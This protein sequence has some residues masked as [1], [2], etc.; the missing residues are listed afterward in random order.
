MPITVNDHEITD[1]EIAAELPGHDTLHLATMAVILRH[2]LRDEAHRL[3]LPATDE[4]SAIA[5]LLAHEV[6]VPEADDASCRRHYAQ[7]P[8][9]FTVGELVEAEHILFQVTERVPLPALRGLAEQTLADL[10]AEPAQFG[11]Q[12]RKLSNCPSATLG[13]N[14]GQL[15]R[16]D[17]VPEFERVLFSADQGAIVPRVVE[18]RFGLHI[19]R[20]VHR[21]AG[22]LLPYE[23]V[24]TQ[25]A[26]ALQQASRDAAWRQYLRV[27]ASR[28]R[29]TGIDLDIADSP[30]LQ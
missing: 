6:T 12:A 2:L 28:A 7:N 27:L 17:T 30:L 3:G 5:A 22:R 1:D 29:I 15:G 19:V 24:C 20:V 8:A 9:R 21:I 18:T 25:I 10:L 26:E 16:G 23:Q 13:G 11:E 4:D 14:L